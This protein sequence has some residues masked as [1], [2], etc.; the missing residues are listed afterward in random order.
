MNQSELQKMVEEISLTSFN[1]PFVHEATF[2]SRLRTTGGRYLLRSHNLEFNPKQY[3]LYGEEEL[4]K[5]IKH[6]L[7]HYHLHI[8]GRGYKHRDADF[9]ELLAHVGGARYCREI[10]GAKRQT[11]VLHEYECQG[12]HL[13]YSRKRRIDTSKYVCGKCRGKLRKKL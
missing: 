4:I 2:N 3:Q 10:P 6:E 12:C 7:C 1:K 11:K 13:L 8:E 5:I 9:K